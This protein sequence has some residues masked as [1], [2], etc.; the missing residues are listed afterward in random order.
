[1]AQPNRKRM[2]TSR[3]ISTPLSIVS[4]QLIQE[5]LRNDYNSFPMQDTR[6]RYALIDLAYA[7]ETDEHLKETNASRIITSLYEHHEL[8]ILQPNIDAGHAFLVSVFLSKNPI[9]QVASKDI[10]KTDAAKQIEAVVG[11]NAD[12]TGWSRQLNLWFKQALK[13]NFAALECEWWTRRTYEFHTD[14]TESFTQ[15]V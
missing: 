1:M 13:Y 12:A 10:T 3:S 11:E 4:Q 7:M 14:T 15:A 6:I 2:N 9:F 8:P 5:Q